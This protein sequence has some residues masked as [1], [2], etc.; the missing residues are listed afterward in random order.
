MAVCEEYK[1]LCFGSLP[2]NSISISVARWVCVC[3]CR[4]DDRLMLW[5]WLN[6]FNYSLS[7]RV[8]EYLPQC[9]QHWDW[10]FTCWLLPILWC[11][12]AA[13]SGSGWCDS[14][15]THRI[16][17]KCDLHRIWIQLNSMAL[18]V[19]VYAA[20]NA[21]LL[22]FSANATPRKVFYNFRTYFSGHNEIEAVLSVGKK[23]HTDKYGFYGWQ[24][25]YMDEKLVC[26]CASIAVKSFTL[27]TY[28]NEIATT[29][30][31]N[32]KT[33]VTLNETSIHIDTHYQAMAIQLKHHSTTNNCRNKAISPSFPEA[34][35]S[36]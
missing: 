23:D 35:I 26:V 4:F 30:E 9:A 31:A 28:L 1:R 16:L 22:P 8:F 15:Q 24:N 25:S 18:C 14:G 21:N 12:M 2:K 27:W 3:M 20:C 6:R 36:P 7:L 33:S 11:L 13:N 17:T 32:F 34:K 29:A 5:R 10:N 19:C